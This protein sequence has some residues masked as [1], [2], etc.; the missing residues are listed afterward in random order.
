MP[1]QAAVPV[2]TGRNG[3]FRFLGMDSGKREDESFDAWAARVQD[4]YEAQMAAHG[5]N[6]GHAEELELVRAVLKNEDCYKHYVQI[7]CGTNLYSVLGVRDDCDPSAIKAAY[8]KIM[9]TCHPD[10][11]QYNGDVLLGK[12]ATADAQRIQHAYDTLSRY[13]TAYDSNKKPYQFDPRDACDEDDEETPF[14]FDPAGWAASGSEAEEAPPDYDGDQE[15]A[16]GRRGGSKRKR[17]GGGQPGAKRRKRSAPPPP[18]P[19]PEGPSPPQTIEIACC[20]QDLLRGFRR[21]VSFQK[22]FED[23]N[24]GVYF[25]RA[26]TLDVHVPARCMPGPLL[27]LKNA[28]AFDHR[29]KRYNDLLV[30]L[31]VHPSPGFRIEHMNLVVDVDVPLHTAL[32]GGTFGKNI[33]GASYGYVQYAFT[34]M[35]RDGDRRAVAGLGLCHPQKPTVYGDLIFN[36][37]VVYG[38]WT[39][40]ER[41]VIRCVFAALK[42]DDEVRR[43]DMIRRIVPDRALPDTIF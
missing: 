39:S 6:A 19:P 3:Y 23:H 37:H 4:A 42:G 13:R 25:N 11:R 2:P 18:P 7:H 21:E 32:V 27:D 34:D 29:L 9:L 30:V 10:K 1:R 20:M 40:Q 36:I 17:A 22:G 24:K 5:Q 43:R 41:E 33:V 38:E 8:R 12:Q 35:L 26:S 31:V 28:G 16:R 14:D 15:E